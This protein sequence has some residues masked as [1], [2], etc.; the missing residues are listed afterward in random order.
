MSIC[1]KDFLAGCSQALIFSRAQKTPV[2]IDRSSSSESIL[3]FFSI[4]TATTLYASAAIRFTYCSPFATGGR[5]TRTIVAII[6]GSM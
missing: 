4:F 3:I 6:S 5:H 2:E 1:Y